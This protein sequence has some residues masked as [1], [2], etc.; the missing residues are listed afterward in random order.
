MDDKTLVH[1][2][3][4]GRFDV[5]IFLTSAVEETFGGHVD[6]FDGDLHKCRIVLAGPLDQSGAISALEVRARDWISGWIN[7]DHSGDTGLAEL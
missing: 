3:R 4:E 1:Q 7:R 5:R 6:I 2:F